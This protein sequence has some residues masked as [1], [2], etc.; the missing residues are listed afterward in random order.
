MKRLIL[1]A[2]CIAACIALVALLASRS[3]AQETTSW[4]ESCYEKIT[5]DDDEGGLWREAQCCT[6]GVGWDCGYLYANGWSPRI[7]DANDCWIKDVPG[8]YRC[9]GTSGSCQESG[10]GGDG[11]GEGGGGTG[12]NCNVGPADSC[13][14]EC[15]SCTRDPIY[16]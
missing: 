4:C 14:A 10:G 6:Q 16:F 9:Q 1:V 7:S 15:S 8:G 11:G 3:N 2:G 5:W 13:P 12:G